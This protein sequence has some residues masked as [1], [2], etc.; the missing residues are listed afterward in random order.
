MPGMLSRTGAAPVAI[1]RC[2]ALQT[3]RVADRDPSAAPA[4]RARLR[5]A[6]RSPWPAVCRYTPS[7]RAVSAALAACQRAMSNAMRPPA[8]ASHSR[9]PRRSAS[10]YCAAYISSFFGT[11]PRSTQVPPTRPASTMR[12]LARRATPRAATRPRRRSRRR[13]RSGRSRGPCVNLRG[14]LRVSR[15]RPMLTGR[16]W[17]LPLHVAQLRAVAAGAA[18]SMPDESPN[19]PA[20]KPRRRRCVRPS[21]ARC[22]TTTRTATTCSTTPEIPD[23]EYDRLFQELQAHRGRASR[24]ARRPTRRRS[25]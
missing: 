12:H 13:A 8:P 17:P 3:L 9:P 11:Q 14:G 4:T 25:A 7:R 6:R 15:R 24:T 23:A 1:R 18:G 10:P 19:G 22:C 16:R 2:R 5:S 20:S 21:C